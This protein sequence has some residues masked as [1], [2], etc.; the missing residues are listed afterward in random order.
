MAEQEQY[1]VRNLEYQCSF[2]HIFIQ[3]N[4]TKFLNH[5]GLVHLKIP[6]NEINFEG[7]MICGNRQFLAIND[8]LIEILNNEVSNLGIREKENTEPNMDAKRYTVHYV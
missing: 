3:G 1:L 5:I 2:C 8:G 7:V 4:A 6:I